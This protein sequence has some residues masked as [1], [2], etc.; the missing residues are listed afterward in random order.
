MSRQCVVWAKSDTTDGSVT[1]DI[2]VGEEPIRKQVDS[3]SKT[4]SLLGYHWKSDSDSTQSVDDCI[5]LCNERCG[6]APTRYMKCRNSEGNE[7]EEQ[8]SKLPVAGKRDSGVTSTSHRWE[9][10][11]QASLRRLHGTECKRGSYRERVAT[12]WDQNSNLS[13]AAGQ[14]IR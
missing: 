5:P 6:P 11:Q 7:L 2:T 14:L 4:M 9:L 13:S 12:T 8:G 10:R 3:P 1:R